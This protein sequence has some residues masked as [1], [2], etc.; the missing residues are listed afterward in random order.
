MLP[1]LSQ[2][3]RGCD[4]FGAR[5][6]ARRPVRWQRDD[7]QLTSLQRLLVD[8]VPV[9]CHQPVKACGLN[10]R[11]QGAILKIPPFEPKGLGVDAG[12]P[13]SRHKP[14]GNTLIN[15]DPQA[16]LAPAREADI[17]SMTRTTS[18]RSSVR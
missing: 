15:R 16:A 5:E 3:K 14:S 17:N 9:V 8:N 6:N 4:V 12:F 11:D 18:L 1:C 13:Q 7:R 2:M 10:G